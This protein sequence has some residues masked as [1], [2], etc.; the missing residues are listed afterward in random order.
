MCDESSSV[1]AETTDEWKQG[2]V[3]KL[4]K[5]YPPRDICNV[6]KTSLFYNVLR[7]KTLCFKG[8]N[9]HGG[10]QSKLKLTIFLVIN[11]DGKE[12]LQP[13]VIGKFQYTRCFKNIKHFPRNSL[14][15]QRHG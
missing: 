14:Q 1:D 2:Q 13:L 5:G 10:K 8:K 15:I 12:K 4:L 11:Y 6:D 7:N 3:L 9:C